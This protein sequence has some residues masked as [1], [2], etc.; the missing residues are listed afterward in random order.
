M[1]LRK[2]QVFELIKKYLN[3]ITEL[4]FEPNIPFLEK[5]LIS[6]RVP[7]LGLFLGSKVIINNVLRSEIRAVQQQLLFDEV[8]EAF[9]KANLDMVV[10]KG[11]VLKD[12]YPNPNHR[13]MGDIDFMVK[14]QY[15]EKATKVLESIGFAIEKNFEI[16]LNATKN[17]ILFELHEALGP[18]E[19]PYL[20]DYEKHLI[21]YKDYEKV[22]QLDPLYNFL[23]NLGHLYFHVSRGG[24]GLKYVIDFYYLFERNQ[25]IFMEIIQ[26]CKKN[27]LYNFFLLLLK[28]CVQELDLK[29]ELKDLDTISNDIYDSFTS[30]IIYGG[31]Y[32]KNHNVDA[33]QTIRKNK[34]GFLLSKLF[35]NIKVLIK[36]I[37]V[38][39]WQYLLYPFYHLRYLIPRIF[40]KKTYRKLKPYTEENDKNITNLFTYLKII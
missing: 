29:I 36:A 3:K 22:Y 19:Y 17:G 26:I 40:S 13:L 28:V 16:E 6:N 38:K 21:K 31:E 11:Q 39:W 12:Y 18:F 37:Q 27:N 15:Y 10:L 9:N 34:V 25:D 8:I 32:G 2:K 23:Q 24:I 20:L 14:P 35:P 30:F 5:V 4:S 1:D 33:I 7:V